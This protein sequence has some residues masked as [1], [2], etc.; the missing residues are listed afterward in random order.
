MGPPEVN[1]ERGSVQF[2]LLNFVRRF[3]RVYVSRA[4][5][6][7]VIDVKVADHTVTV[8]CPGAHFQVV[9]SRIRG[10]Q[11]HRATLR[12]ARVFLRICSHRGWG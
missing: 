2:P 10:W 12:L 7:S 9:A 6:R 4:S 8:Y 11:A 5:H 3:R 1:P